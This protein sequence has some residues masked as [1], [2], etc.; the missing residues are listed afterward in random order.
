MHTTVHS[1]Y[2]AV[3]LAFTTCLNT[4]DIGLEGVAEWLEPLLQ[5]MWQ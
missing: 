1:L 3:R 4:G 5:D 2:T